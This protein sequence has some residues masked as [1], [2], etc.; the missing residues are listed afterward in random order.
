MAAC[1]RSVRFVKRTKGERRLALL[2]RGEK[3]CGGGRQRYPPVTAKNSNFLFVFAL[4]PATMA[5]SLCSP[6][7]ISAMADWCRRVAASQP[8]YPSSYH[9]RYLPHNA[10]QSS[11]FKQSHPSTHD[12]NRISTTQMVQ[13]AFLFCSSLA[14]PFFITSP[15]L[16][17][18][19]P[20][21]LLLFSAYLLFSGVVYEP[22]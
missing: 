22:W 7:L 3:R 6:I 15:S 17:C 20:S 16:P 18:V 8:R 10:H 14:P 2:E 11:F 13:L 19:F 12:S 9:Q 1:V 5:T 4:R 21:F